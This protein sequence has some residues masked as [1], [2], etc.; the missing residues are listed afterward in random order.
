MAN[1]KPKGPMA[2]TRDSFK[3]KKL[4]IE[5]RLKELKVGSKVVVKANGRYQ[6]GMP[7]RRFIGKIGTVDEKVGQSSYM[8]SFPRLK[9]IIIVDIEHLKEVKD[10]SDSDA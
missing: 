9:K 8:L 10:W 2:N 6:G 3:G 1:K 5:Q 7:A 4:T